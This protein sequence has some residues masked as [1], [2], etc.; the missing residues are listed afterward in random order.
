M[1][2]ALAGAGAWVV[3][4]VRSEAKGYNTMSK[5]KKDYPQAYLS[6]I[7]LDLSSLD[8]VESFVSGMR[9]RTFNC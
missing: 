8:S 6:L 7:K 3:L 5:I 1:A 4:A 2:Y 9:M